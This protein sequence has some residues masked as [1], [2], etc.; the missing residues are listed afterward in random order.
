[1]LLQCC[2]LLTAESRSN[3]CL[4]LCN[5]AKIRHSEAALFWSLSWAHAPDTDVFTAGLNPLIALCCMSVYLSVSIF[6]V[7]LYLISWRHKKL[8]HPATQP[9]KQKKKQLFWNNTS[10]KAN[11]KRLTVGIIQQPRFNS[12]DTFTSAVCNPGSTKESCNQVHV[13]DM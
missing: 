12:S 13:E 8:P 4:C 6:S 3:I 10:Y 9:P 5:N 2:L 11:C 7:C 1:M